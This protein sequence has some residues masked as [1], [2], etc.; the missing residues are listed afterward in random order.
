MMSWRRDKKKNQPG[1]FPQPHLTKDLIEYCYL[2]KGKIISRNIS[3]SIE[4][5]GYV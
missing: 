5:D 3:Q 4:L 1:N 2:T